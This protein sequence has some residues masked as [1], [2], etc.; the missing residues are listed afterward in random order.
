M[1]LSLDIVCTDVSSLKSLQQGNCSLSAFL[2]YLSELLGY[3]RNG[4]FFHKSLHVTHLPI[5]HISFP[6]GLIESDSSSKENGT[7]MV[8]GRCQFLFAS[9]T[10]PS[11]VK[12]ASFFFKKISTKW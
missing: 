7:V 11:V 6:R 12:T 5:V 9:T 4:F 3:Y 2:S 10:F 8:S 1:L